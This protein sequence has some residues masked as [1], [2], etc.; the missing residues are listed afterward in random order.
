MGAGA[1]AWAVSQG[2]R[3]LGWGT[4]AVSV[5][6]LLLGVA[7]THSSVAHLD[8]AQNG[9]VDWGP[10]VNQTF[11]FATPLAF[12]AI[13]G[14]FSERSGV[15]N[16]GLEG[17]MLSGRLLRHPRRRQVQLVGARPADGDDLRAP[18]SGCSTRFCR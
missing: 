11:V 12:A 10:M 14:M 4:I 9:A 8:G 3:K 15:V 6:A 2:V 18:C 1:G 13:G 5:L 17:M 16:I 7:A